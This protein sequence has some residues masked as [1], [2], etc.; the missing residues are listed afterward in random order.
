MARPLRYDA[1]L[2]VRLTSEQ[3]GF[4]KEYT[5]RSDTDMSQVIRDYIGKLELGERLD[6]SEFNFH[7][8]SPYEMPPAQPQIGSY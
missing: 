1:V 3:F 2:R 8:V 4:L 7:T 6:G 5:A